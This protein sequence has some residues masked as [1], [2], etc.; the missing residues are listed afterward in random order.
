MS[1]S[2][3]IDKRT[4]R[5]R[6]FAGSRRLGSSCHMPT[7]TPTYFYHAPPALALLALLPHLEVL[8]R[9]PISNLPLPLLL[10]PPPPRHRSP[11]PIA[12]HTAPFSGPSSL[13]LFARFEFPIAAPALPALCHLE[14]AFDQMGAAARAG[15]IE[16]YHLQFD[17]HLR[18]IDFVHRKHVLV[19][20]KQ[21]K[22]EKRKRE[23][24]ENK[25]QKATTHGEREMA[26]AGLAEFT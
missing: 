1:S 9:P 4:R 3:E 11:I 13:T 12:P 26:T 2:C 7:A 21:I 25:L 20:E 15:G 23:Y 6:S 5:R 10:K 8:V 17:E 16:N 14:W 22:I 18:L 24:A 19:L